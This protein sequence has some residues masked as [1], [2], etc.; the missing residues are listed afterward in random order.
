M[1]VSGRQPAAVAGDAY[2]TLIDDQLTEERARKVSLEQRA[3]GVITTSGA[4]VTL[5]F[6]FTAA[7]NGTN[8]LRL[9]DSARLELFVSLFLLL[10]AVVVAVIVGFPVTYLEVDNKALTKLIHEEDWTNPEVVEARRRTAEAITGI[11][12]SARRANG[13]K[14]NLT[15]GALALE[16]LGIVTLAI[17]A[18]ATL[19]GE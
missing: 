17:G 15:T 10:T 9:P 1:A 4:V 6:A 5:V 19:L 14:A 8:A 13:I 11:I 12:I 7:V 18:M 2:S 16:V 3:V